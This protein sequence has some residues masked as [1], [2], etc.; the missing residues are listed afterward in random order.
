MTG[1]PRAYDHS[2]IFTGC[3]MHFSQGRD[4]LHAMDV[5]LR[6]LRYALALA[7]QGNFAR[8]AKSV[9]ISQPAFSRG[10]KQL[11]RRSGTL[12]FERG[13]GRVRPTDA[14]RIF[15]EQAREVASRAADLGRGMDLLRGLDNGALGIGFAPYP[16]AMMA[17]QTIA[18]LVREHPGARLR[19]S[20]NMSVD[21]PD[22]LSNGEVDVAVM[23]VG[24][25]PDDPQLS[26]TKM[27]RHQGYLAVRRGHPLLAQRG[28][29]TFAD[30][31][32]FPIAAPTRIPPAVLK[33]V[34]EEAAENNGTTAEVKSIPSIACDSITMLKTISADS[35]AVTVMPLSMV[36][37]EV[38]AGVLAVLPMVESWLNATLVVGRLAHRS[39][40]PL[41]ERFVRIL[42]EEDRKAYE[43]EQQTERELFDRK[44]GFRRSAAS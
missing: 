36:M 22:L 5:D 35:D 2:C 14:G 40:S 15:L 29:L 6:L 12:L 11:E 34:L 19:V 16:A 39:L 41:G 13:R 33:Q 23:D 3:P 20:Q 18:R 9:H 37:P 28:P 10:I 4:T 7:E 42:L 24:E 30:I 43:S 17:G 38:R 1:V 26:L 27:Q 44:L 32:R 25:V 31:L 8:A 21:L